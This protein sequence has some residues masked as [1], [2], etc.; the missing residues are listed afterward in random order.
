MAIGP[1]S[2]AAG[3]P[4]QVRWRDD[5]GTERYLGGILGTVGNTSWSLYDIV[6]SAERMRVISSGNVGIGVSTP[7]SILHVANAATSSEVV[8]AHFQNTG[9]GSAIATVKIGEG[10]PESQYGVLG[11]YG[12]DNSFRIGAVAGVSGYMSFHTGNIGSTNLSVNERM[13]IDACLLY[14]SDAAD[15]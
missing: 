15:E 13:R 14:T 3:A 6:N 12:A 4:G 2:A 5:T 10:S 9:G 7:D 1:K 8:L 11:H